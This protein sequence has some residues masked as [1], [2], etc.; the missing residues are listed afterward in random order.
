MLI[1]RLAA[2]LHQEHGAA[3]PGTDV[4]RRFPASGPDGTPGAPALAAYLVI[5]L[6]TRTLD[7]GATPD[8][9]L[10][11]QRVSTLH[12]LDELP[13][14]DPECVHLRLIVTA[15]GDQ[16]T[17]AQLRRLL[18]RYA[19]WLEREGRLDQALDVLRLAARTWPGDIPPRDFTELALEVGRINRQLARLAHADDAYAAAAEGAAS[20]GNRVEQLRAR[21][22]RLAVRRL[23]GR[24]EGLE[25][26]LHAVAA[27]CE[28]DPSLMA[29]L[30]LVHADIGALCTARGKPA[31]AVLEMLRAARTASTVPE[32]LHVIAGLGRLLAELGER[33][34][35]TVLLEHV[36]TRAAD[37]LLR[38]TADLE[39]MDLASADG[40]RILFERLRSGLG[41][42]IWRLPPA[43]R[44][45]FHYR[46]GIGFVRF[47]QAARARQ[48]WTTGRMLAIEERLDDWAVVL[49][50]APQAP[51]RLREREDTAASDDLAPLLADARALVE[52]R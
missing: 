15:L 11:L 24:L 6:V 34:V 48:S 41:E 30:P 9:A 52:D 29:L 39:R 8:V 18:L 26:E 20:T 47:G 32:R 50:D 4:R 36:A 46:S 28:C 43:L 37:R 19:G 25:A 10:A 40:N 33:D 7:A 38:A 22:G 17:G 2:A 14:T 13:S 35:A 3:H 42:V 1:G 16:A 5:R 27:E 44:A 21:L 23:Q 49:R 51:G 12:F 45:E 31:E